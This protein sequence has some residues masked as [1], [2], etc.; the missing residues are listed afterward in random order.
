[1]RDDPSPEPTR[2]ARRA[3]VY[4]CFEATSG[5]AGAPRRAACRWRAS[6]PRSQRN[7]KTRGSPWKLSARQTV[8]QP[9]LRGPGRACDSSSTASTSPPFHA[10]QARPRR[11]GPCP[12]T[13]PQSPLCWRRPAQG[14]NP[15]TGGTH[16][17]A[18]HRVSLNKNSPPRFLSL[19]LLLFV[20]RAFPRF[21]VFPDAPP[22][23]SVFIMFIR[24][25]VCF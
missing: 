8:R 22:S 16:D 5:D 6:R 25:F 11:N 21:P 3:S 17:D 19:S 2:L 23:F 20:L 15:D 18:S 12:K 13:P 1:M 10:W 4:A 14:L 9:M 24:F 7:R